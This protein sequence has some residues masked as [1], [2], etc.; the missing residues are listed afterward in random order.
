MAQNEKRGGAFNVYRL[1]LPNLPDGLV[2]D[3]PDGFVDVVS[4]LP[5]EI[6]FAHGLAGAAIVGFC[7]RLVRQG[8]TLDPESFRPN[9]LFINLLH[10][11]IATNA[12][13]D[14][15]LQMA[16]RQ[17]HTGA[18]NLLDGRTP[19]PRGAVPPHDIIGGFQVKDGVIVPSS[20][21]ANPNH[22]LLSQDGLFKLG[23]KF[24]HDAL[25][26]RLAKVSTP[27]R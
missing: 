24:L 20:Y 16:A 8:L 21:Q 18:V 22:R 26:D 10:E 3:N 5:S 27:S 1:R 23:S 14:P 15:E 4:L 9:R 17:Q 7:T 6:C 19:T 11:V 2:P 25:M 13:A 12:P